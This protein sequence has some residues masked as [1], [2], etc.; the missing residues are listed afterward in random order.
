MRKDLDPA[1]SVGSPCAVAHCLD[2][3]G[4]VPCAVPSIAS[5]MPQ[6]AAF[7]RRR[8]A[9]GVH[10][11]WLLWGHFALGMLD[12]MTTD[13]FAALC[14]LCHPGKPSPRLCADGVRV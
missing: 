8:P 2:T 11:G 6:S 1:C 10:V 7:L 13:P 9:A 12:D 4:L 3:V 14:L 5:C